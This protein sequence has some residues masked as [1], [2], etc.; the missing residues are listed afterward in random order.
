MAGVAAFGGIV[1]LIVLVVSIPAGLVAGK[2]NAALPT[3]RAGSGWWAVLA[4]ST[5]GAVFAGG[6]LPV[7][8]TAGPSI[9]SATAAVIGGLGGGLHLQQ[10]V[11]RRRAARR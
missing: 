5:V 7:M 6:G 3:V 2:V 10:H 4:V 1:M 11:L 9:A 8:L